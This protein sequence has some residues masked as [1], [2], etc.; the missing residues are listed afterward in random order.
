[1]CAHWCQERRPLT[2]CVVAPS[3]AGTHEIFIG[4]DGCHF[5][6]AV[7]YITP[8]RI[9]CTDFPVSST[10]DLETKVDRTTSV[11][12]RQGRTITLRSDNDNALISSCENSQP[13][14]P[15]DKRGSYEMQSANSHAG[16]TAAPE[17]HPVCVH[18][19]RRS[20]GRFGGEDQDS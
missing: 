2:Y 10:S 13:L 12:S 11:S 7:G 19:S 4:S 5:L 3:Q 16:A 15:G 6:S 17:F 1:M 18:I 20:S 9:H 14:T 8:A